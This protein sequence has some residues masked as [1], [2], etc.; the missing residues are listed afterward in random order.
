[1]DDELVEFLEGLED[2][3]DDAMNEWSSTGNDSR[4]LAWLARQWEEAMDDAVQESE[5][6]EYEVLEDE[7]DSVSPVLDLQQADSGHAQ[8]SGRSLPDRVPQVPLLGGV[9]ESRVEEE[10]SE[11]EVIG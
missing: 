9:H 8:G 6:P 5:T 10:D 3:F 4:I 7:D 2:E 1:M 11:E